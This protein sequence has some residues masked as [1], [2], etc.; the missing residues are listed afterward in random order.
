MQKSDIENISGLL[1]QLEKNTN[2]ISRKISAKDILNSADIEVIQHNYT[3]RRIISEK[4]KAC[5]DTE[6][7][8]KLLKENKAVADKIDLILRQEKDNLD[9]LND[10]VKEKGNQIK[11]LLKQK[12]VLIYT[13][14]K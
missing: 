6:S 10:K 9:R 3:D 5:L 1:D 13:K 8:Q 12:S 4:L 11:S 7:G 14:E 2:I